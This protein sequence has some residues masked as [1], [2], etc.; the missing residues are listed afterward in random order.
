MARAAAPFCDLIGPSGAGKSTLARRIGARLGLPVVHLD[1]FNWNPGWVQTEVGLFRQ[2]VAAA[3]AG[4]AWVMDGNYL[5]HLDLRLP[6][7]QAVIWLDLPRYI[8]FPRAVWRSLRNYGRD[9][10]D[11]RSR[12]PRAG[13]SVV[14]H[15]LGV[16]LPNARPRPAC[17]ADGRSARGSPRR[18]LAVATQGGAI[19]DRAASLTLM[20]RSPSAAIAVTIIANRQVRAKRKSS[21]IEGSRHDAASPSRSATGSGRCRRRRSCRAP[22]RRW[23][24]RRGR[25]AS[26]SATRRAVRPTLPR[27]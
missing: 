3:A 1:I 4:D 6:R 7:A 12:L 21:R 20:A 17:A 22:R 27:A 10:D 23:I 14:P 24:I 2:R 11:A 13:R 8:Y 9:R 16:E 5:A 19:R 25:C 15:R 26:S 18:H